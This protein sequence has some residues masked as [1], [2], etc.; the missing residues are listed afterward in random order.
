MYRSYIFWE[1]NA[2]ER[3]SDHTNSEGFEGGDYDKMI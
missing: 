3:F 2:M 1:G